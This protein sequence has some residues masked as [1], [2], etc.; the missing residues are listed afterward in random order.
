[1]AQ[2][3]KMCDLRSLPVVILKQAYATWWVRQILGFSAIAQRRNIVIALKTLHNEARAVA[4]APAPSSK[5]LD[6]EA[7]P[8]VSETLRQ[9]Y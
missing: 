2:I 6:V 9:D 5:H 8:S 4:S 3:R 1:M 7:H